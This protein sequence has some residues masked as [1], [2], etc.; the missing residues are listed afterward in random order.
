MYTTNMGRYASREEVNAN[1]GLRKE[2]E[3]VKYKLCSMDDEKLL[4]SGVLDPIF[5]ELNK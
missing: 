5:E 4:A 3:N 1:E 2:F